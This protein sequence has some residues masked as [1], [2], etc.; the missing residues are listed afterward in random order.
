MPSYPLHFANGD[1]VNFLGNEKS[2]RDVTAWLQRRKQPAI[3]SVYCNTCKRP[4]VARTSPGEEFVT[5]VHCNKRIEY[6]MEDFAIICGNS[7]NGKTY[8]CK[9]LASAFDYQLREINADDINSKEDLDIILKTT[10]NKDMTGKKK[11]IVIDDVPAIRR[12]LSRIRASKDMKKVFDVA[13]ISHYPVIFTTDTYKKSYG[14]KLF[15]DYITKNAKKI[16]IN[17]PANRLLV[18]FLE[19]VDEN[20]DKKTLIEIAQ[21]SPSVRSAIKSVQTNSINDITEEKLSN[22][23]LLKMLSSRLMPKDVTRDN[24]HMICNSITLGRKTNIDDLV[25]VMEVFAD[26]DYRVKGKHQDI[27]PW[28]I[29]HVPEKIEN[30]WLANNYKNTSFKRN[31]LEFDE[32]IKSVKKSKKT[33]SKKKVK[34]KTVTLDGFI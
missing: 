3:V 16:W 22:R 6:P 19:K 34:S 12:K 18:K 7:G 31:H 9:Q 2:V 25:D 14:G 4:S 30:V 21:K 20:V 11:L 10:N 28:I 13:R 15:P 26:F 27:E 1:D 5:C 29:N 24:I 32:V 23:Q 33:K 17:K 8:L